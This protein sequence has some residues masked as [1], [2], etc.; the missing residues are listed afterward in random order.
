[1]SQHNYHISDELLTKYLLGEASEEE[2]S[3]VEEWMNRDEANKKH[4]EELEKIWKESKRLAA[5]STVD[6]NAAWQRFQAR[7]KNPQ[8]QAPVVKMRSTGWW[9]VAAL[10]V[11]IAGAAYLGY[12]FLNKGDVKNLQVAT[13]TST[14]IDTLPDGSIVTLNKNSSLDYPSQFKDSTRTIALKGEA[15]FNITPN[16]QK[17]FIIHVN[18]LSIR[19]VGTSFNVKSVNGTTEVIV[20]TGIVQVIKNNKVMELR[21]KEG[22]KISQRDSLVQKEQVKDELYNYYRSKEFVCRNTPLWKLVE[23]LKE[24]YGVDIVFADPKLRNYPITTTFSNQS[25]QTILDVISETFNITVSKEEHTIIL[26]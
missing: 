11:I 23:V 6:E 22:L 20:E 17:P 5:Q 8:Q 15:F 18:D 7:V 16:K 19:V 1:M 4:F 21:P 25:L 2:G 14:L 13:T 10:F 24:A 26:K 3:F 9:R 12:K